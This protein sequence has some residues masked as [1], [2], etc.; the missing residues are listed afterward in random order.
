VGAGDGMTQPPTSSADLAA[1]RA[2]DELLATKVNLPRPRPDRLA[3]ARLFQW[4]DEGIAQA[5]ILVCAPA[6]F[7]KTTL[8]APGAGLAGLGELPNDGRAWRWPSRTAASSA[9]TCCRYWKPARLA[10]STVAVARSS[11]R[12]R[13]RRFLVTV[14]SSRRAAV[15]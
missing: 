5:L 1:P 8:L 12:P 11:T 13:R 3:R 10:S 2:R 4:L 9:S 14:T 15:R 7:G 6:G